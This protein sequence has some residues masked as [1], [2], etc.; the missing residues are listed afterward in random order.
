MLGANQGARQGWTGVPL[1]SWSVIV[2][3][4]IDYYQHSKLLHLWGR[5]DL[6]FH[7]DLK[8]ACR[9]GGPTLWTCRRQCGA[10]RRSCSSAAPSPRT[11]R[12]PSSNCRPIRSASLCNHLPKEIFGVSRILSFIISEG[13]REA[14]NLVKHSPIY[15]QSEVIYHQ[16]QHGK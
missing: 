7:F 13:G 4:W 12:Q 15:R 9:A 8:L 10:H 6:Y 5:S 11:V 3:Y 1:T 2:R 16:T 14:R